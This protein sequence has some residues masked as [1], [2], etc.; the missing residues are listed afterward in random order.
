MV[1]R[2]TTPALTNSSRTEAT[3]AR[4]WVLLKGRSGTGED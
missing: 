4:S 2:Y 1:E 3:P